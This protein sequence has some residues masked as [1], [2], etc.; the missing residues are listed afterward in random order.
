MARFVQ[1]QYNCGSTI[2][3]SANGIIM[4]PDYAT[5]NSTEI[6]CRW[7]I[8]SSYKLL[9]LKITYLDIGNCNNCCDSNYLKIFNRRQEL[10]R[11]CNNREPQD[12]LLKEKFLI[13]DFRAN[14]Y[15]ALNKGI[16][17]EYSSEPMSCKNDQFKCIEEEV[18][19]SKKRKCD[20]IFDCEDHSDE[21]NCTRCSVGQAACDYS[22]TFCFSPTSQR[23]DGTVD[24]PGAEDELNCFSVCPGKLRCGNSGECYNKSQQCNGNFDCR[25]GYDERNCSYLSCGK[26]FNIKLHFICRNG[27]CIERIYLNDGLD[28]CGDGSDEFSGRNTNY[29][30]LASFVGVFMCVIFIFL[31]CRWFI[32]RRN[33]NYLMANPPEFPRRRRDS[34]NIFNENDF[35]RGG[36]I[37]EAYLQSRRERERRQRK[38]LRE[39]KSKIDVVTRTRS[40]TRPQAIVPSTKVPKME[41]KRNVNSQANLERIVFENFVQKK[42]L[43]DS[44]DISPPSGDDLSLGEEFS[45][46]TLMEAHEEKCLLCKAKNNSISKQTSNQLFEVRSN[47]YIMDKTCHHDCVLTRCRSDSNLKNISASNY[48]ALRKNDDVIINVVS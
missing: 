27:H 17:L 4:S 15:T 35:R 46:K 30:V 5:I 20:G 7:T 6:F 25:N 44:S 2:V 37:F 48:G 26:P 24:C 47:S 8:Y 10:A 34:D 22:S 33:I 13:L 32:T 29:I 14:N 12:V 43:S 38:R 28:D 3:N 21:V 31:I 41:T 9:H 18:C 1:N 16:K 23:C 42:E 40:V 45:P 19:I 11:Y 39:S 36:V